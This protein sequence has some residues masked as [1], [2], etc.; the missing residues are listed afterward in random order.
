[1]KTL[2][3]YTTSI[4]SKLVIETYEGWLNKHD[5]V[6]DIGCGDGILSEI[7]RD[8][9]AIKVTGCDIENYLQKNIPFVAIT[10]EA[11]LPF[12]NNSFD[13]VM[14]NDVLHHM[15]FSTQEKLIKEALRVSKRV[16]IF[17]DEPTILGSITDWVINKFHNLFMPLPLTFRHH[18]QWAQLFDSM[19]IKYEFKKV[20]KQLFYPLN[21]E[22]FLLYRGNVKNRS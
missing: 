20:R 18:I 15:N 3:E 4:R 11:V 14:F 22:S 5:R 9:F 6:L 10:K 17:E 12:H 21:H 8:R 16:L 13:A 19:N 2:T 7:L 1:M